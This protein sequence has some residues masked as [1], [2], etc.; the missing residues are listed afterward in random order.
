MIYN[1]VS[2]KTVISKIYRDLNITYELNEGEIF[3]W[4]SEALS[5]IGAFSQYKEITESLEFKEGKAKLP[6]GFE[7]LVDIR[8]CD[9]P[10]YWSTDTN[11]YKYQCTDCKIP[12]DYNCCDSNHTFYINDSY[13]ISNIK[14][15]ETN[16]VI[17]TYL[18]I[19]TD[20][21][22]YPL[23]PDDVYYMKALTA[24]ITYM[25]DRQEWRKGKI[26]DKVYNDSERDWLFYVNSARGSANMPNIAQLKNLKNTLRRLLPIPNDYKS[27]FR[28]F[29]KTENLRKDGRY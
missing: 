1:F 25:L 6:C 11:R 5:L 28:R 3:E 24:Y 21:E 10:M 4:I 20:S 2:A 22:G 8:Y 12:D 14:C 7:K 13:V 27:G 19:P 15:D 29:N 23:I 9:K 16:K 18:G 17:I 26:P